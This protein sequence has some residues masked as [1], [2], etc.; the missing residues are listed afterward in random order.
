M[1]SEKPATSETPSPST[2]NTDT[3]TRLCDGALGPSLNVDDGDLKKCGGVLKWKTF[4]TSCTSRSKCVSWSEGFWPSQ[5][6][7]DSAS[8]QLPH[9]VWGS[10]NR[11]S[12]NSFVWLKMESLC[13]TGNH[14]SMWHLLGLI[15]SLPYVL[16]RLI[17]TVLEI[18]VHL[19]FHPLS[20]KRKL[21]FGGVG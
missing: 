19:F 18:S 8:R 4:L 7:K 12:R 9:Q 17:W 1:I 2:I 14:N 20:Q 21:G 15:V 3:G 11:N 6:M 16:A 5:E 10:R 13:N